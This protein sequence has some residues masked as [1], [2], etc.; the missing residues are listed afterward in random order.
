ME[1]NNT[2]YHINRTERSDKIDATSQLTIR[3]GHGPQEFGTSGR[4]S[5]VTIP[6]KV[7]GKFIRHPRDK[8][9]EPTITVFI[10][11]EL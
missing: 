1:S 7:R 10:C 5:G 4:L 8:E 3:G 6:F 11:W 9:A 2:N